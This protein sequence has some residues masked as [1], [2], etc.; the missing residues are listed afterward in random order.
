MMNRWFYFV[1]KKIISKIAGYCADCRCSWFS[2]WLIKHFMRHFNIQLDEAQVKD[3]RQFES[4]NAFFTRELEPAARPIADEPNAICSPC[5]GKLGQFGLIDQGSLL[6]AK[7]HDYSLI[8]LL[9]NHHNMAQI[10]NGGSYI[11]GYLAPSDYH[12]VHIPFS[13]VLQDMIFV[14]GALFPV[15]PAA[16]QEVAGLF[17]RNERVISLFKTEQ[18]MMA[19]ILVG[20]LNV[21]SMT[22]AWHGPVLAK[23]G[24]E[25]WNYEQRRIH[26]DRGDEL[27]YFKLGGSTVIVLFEKQVEWQLDSHQPVLKMGQA[28]G[29]FL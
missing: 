20:A 5:D 21:G 24:I 25:S 12:R 1:P 9:A 23:S 13:G 26:L 2:R 27:G 18:G 28:L 8:S 3:I 19:V 7:G 4:F 29:R 11:T 6:Q 17:A 22:T 15:F 16:T 10:F 14:P